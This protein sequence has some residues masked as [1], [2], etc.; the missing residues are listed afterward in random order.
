MRFAVTGPIA[1]LVPLVPLVTLV[2]V[3]AR[4]TAGAR[5]PAA[6]FQEHVFVVTSDFPAPA[7]QTAALAL[8]AP[9]SASPGLEPIGGEASVRHFAGLHYVVNPDLDSVQVIDP[10][11]FETRVEIDTGPGSRPQ[12]VLVVRPDR[13]Y[14]SRYERTHLLRV[15][16]RTGLGS[17]AVDL[18]VLA[19]ADG[20]PEMSM[21]ARHGRHLFVQLQRI[22]RESAAPV[23]PS[24]LAVVDL[25]TDT[26][27]DVDPLRA[28]VQ[29]IELVGL[30]PSFRMQVDRAA[31]RLYVSTPN[32]L[33][34][35]DGGIEEIDLVSLRTRGFVTSEFQLGGDLTGFVLVSSELGYVL[36]HTD[37]LLSSHLTAFSRLDGSHQGEKFV[38]FTEVDN[39]A[40]DRRTGQLFFPDSDGVRVFDAASGEQLTSAPIDVGSRPT[41]LVVARPRPAQ[42]AR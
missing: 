16:P 7:G 30:V 37:L 36:T 28:G 13:A 19:D 20:L 17:D 18:S 1:V 6:G 33:L 12:D 25:A 26:L 24:M 11:T 35:G 5:S 21:L 32:G 27:V 15:D 29:A 14:V 42:R 31:R 41:D 38:T 8:E 3:A 34:T 40:F 22:D 39:L 4:A 9:W 2:L 23:A 10:R